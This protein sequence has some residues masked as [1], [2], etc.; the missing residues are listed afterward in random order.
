M[1]SDPPSAADGDREH[2]PA[3]GDRT[4]N[5]QPVADDETA[6]GGT[7]EGKPVADGGT[8]G[9]GT[10]DGGTAEDEPVAD[11][12]TAGDGT[13]D[14]KPAAD[15]ETSG[16]GTA[17][18]Q[19]VADDEPAG[20]GTS[21]DETADETA[22]D[23]EDDASQHTLVQDLFVNPSRWAIWPA[24]GILRWA[25]R[26]TPGEP[27][28][29]IYRSLPSLAFKP[30]EIHSVEL[31]DDSVDVTLTAP[32]IAS[33]GSPLPLSD[34][35]RIVQDMRPPGRGALSAWLDGPTDLFM[36]VLEATMMRY[37]AAFALTTGGAVNA[38]ISAANLVGH[39]APLQALPEHR[40]TGQPG[41]VPEG[42]AALAALFVGAPSA[43]GLAAL[44]HAF[45][46]LPARVEEFAGARV[47]TLRPAS[48][49]GPVMRVL[50]RYSTLATA[51]IEVIVNG[52]ADEGA[53]RWAREPDRCASLRLLCERYVGSD[54][55]STRLFIELDAGNIDP[56]TFGEA[57]L[58]GM[59][60]LGA[61]S[62]GVRL[63]LR[64]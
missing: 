48:L 57:I 47:R 41:A 6:G 49:G 27:R 16:D 63:P 15:D 44:V 60:V 20:D 21:D 61:P 56:A 29:L 39:T 51:G 62:E 24:I 53:R 13:A 31:K 19:P 54:A 9:G 34:I 64:I 26:N 11:D 46:G 8:A 23:D 1:P 22:D 25:L 14:G 10:V 38:V 52:G 33:P 42:A 37:S 2:G 3:T 30:N 58:G 17:D 50:G 43:D 28:R 7:A 40:L 35:A 5:G 45:T 12:E 55:V 4:A 32:G 18:G 59:A 36:Q